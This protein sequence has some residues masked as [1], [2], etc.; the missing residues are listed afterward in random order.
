MKDMLRNPFF[1]YIVVPVLIALWPLWLVA[2]GNPGA[3]DSWDKEKQQF[4]DAEKLIAK[5]LE[6][7]PQR[8]DYAKAKK[9]AGEFDYAIAIDQAAKLCRILPSSYRL[10]SGPIVKSRGGQSNQDA[11]MTVSKVDIEKFA[12][13]ISL[14]QFRWPSLQC[15][16]LKLTKEKAAKDI[17]KA[18]V[19]FKY[20]R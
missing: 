19:R 14:I 9:K 7:D 10:S 1:Y 17:W 5:I 8:L 13:F 20:Y 6:L 2:A 15:T 12:R 11:T 4:N 18:D 3:R 16:N